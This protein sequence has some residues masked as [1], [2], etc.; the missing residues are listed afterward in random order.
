[1]SRETRALFEMVPPTFYAPEMRGVN[2]VYRFEIDDG[3][4]WTMR[5]DD[6]NVTIAEG[7]SDEAPPSCTISGSDGDVAAV[8]RGEQNMVTALLQGRISVVGDLAVGQRL[9]GVL[10]IFGIG[11][12]RSPAP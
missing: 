10:F 9:V 12:P 4:R 7:I 1:M 11:E 6:G 8:L 5:V 3:E 2:T